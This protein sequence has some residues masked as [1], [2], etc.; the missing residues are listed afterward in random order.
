[1]VCGWAHQDGGAATVLE[2]AHNA[3]AADLGVNVEADGLQLLG[4]ARRR[5]FLLEGH[6]RIGMQLLVKLFEVGILPSDAL[7]D[8]LDEFRTDSS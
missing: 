4:H 6:F 2:H 8:F 7:F 5:L 1:M 3:V